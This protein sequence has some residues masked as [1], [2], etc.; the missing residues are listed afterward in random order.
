MQ[1][2]FAPV[3]A[4]ALILAGATMVMAES[5]VLPNRD[6]CWERVYDDAH[7]KAHPMQQVVRI[8]LFYL[9]SRWPPPSLGVTFVALEM[10]LRART[11]G[12]MRLTTVSGDSASRALAACAASRNGAPGVSGSKP[13]RRD[14]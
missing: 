4:A 1:L 9:P 10:N 13:E 5:Q 6:G 3:L 12:A 7:L 2:T 14:R 8:R 11:M